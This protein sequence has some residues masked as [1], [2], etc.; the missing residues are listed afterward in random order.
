MLL[1]VTIKTGKP[2][3]A[4][5][6]IVKVAPSRERDPFHQEVFF[7]YNKEDTCSIF[8]SLETIQK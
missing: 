4:G 2:V 6:R 5:M 8:N 1:E 3:T 7:L